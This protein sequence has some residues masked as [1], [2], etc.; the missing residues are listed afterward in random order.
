MFA[1]RPTIENLQFSV[2]Q[3][4][5]A[6]ARFERRTTEQRERRCLRVERSVLPLLHEFSRQ[7]KAIADVPRL[8]RA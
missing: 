3:A 7:V 6:L 4:A 5:C 2:P 1:P 8:F